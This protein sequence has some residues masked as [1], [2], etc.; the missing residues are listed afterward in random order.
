MFLALAWLFGSIAGAVFIVRPKPD[1]PVAASR[2]R[3]AAVFAAAFVG[4]PL[5]MGLMASNG[6]GAPA[7]KTPTEL[8]ARARAELDDMR[9]HP[10]KYLSLERTEGRKSGF[11]T[12][13]ILS[14]EIRS[15]SKIGVKDPVI[16]CD[17]YS[18]TDTQLGHVRQTLFKFV[19][20]GQ[21]TT[22]EAFNM[23]FVNSNWGRYDCRITNATV[24]APS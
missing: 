23:G 9:G 18:E 5:L 2:G 16:Q 14:G 4:L 1:W 12:V 8:A 6:G 20:A 22:F 19:P 13:F 7:A 15:A 10:A 11:D 21:S 24:T 3:A 17:L